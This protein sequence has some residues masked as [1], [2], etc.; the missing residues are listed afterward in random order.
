[1]TGHAPEPECPSDELLAG[2]IERRVSDAEREAIEQHVAACATCADVAAASFPASED[3][4][5]R[6]VAEPA[7]VVAVERGPR[8]SAAARVRPS[9]TRWAIAAGLVLAT[10]ALAYAALDAGLARVRDELARRAS[11]ALG[12]PVT[13]G[14]LGVGLSSD[15][16]GLVIRV[17]DVR[18]GGD[19][20]LSAE[21]ID[22]QLSLAALVARTLDVQRLRLL[23]PVIHLGGP[24][25]KDAGAKA[26]HV[27]GAN[28]LAA[29]LG[30]ASLEIVD[31][32]LVAAAA[33]GALRVDHVNGTASPNGSRVDLA[34]S[35]TGAGGTL[36]VDGSIPAGPSGELAATLTGQALDVG[37]LPLV[38][39]RVTGRADLSVALTGTTDSPVLQGRGVIRGGRARGWNPLPQALAALGAEV[40]PNVGAATGPDLAFD[41][42]R[43][44]ILRNA[45][46]WKVP[47][48]YASAPGFSIDA[49]A[50]QL[51]EDQ[52]LEGAG[53]VQLAAPLAAVVIAAVP[54]LVAQRDESG[55]LALPITIGG[56]LAAPQLTPLV[57]APAAVEEPPAG[58]ADTDGAANAAAPD[59]AA[60]AAPA[61]AS[62]DDAP[63]ADEP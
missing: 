44:V 29:T 32:T 30:R 57:A 38:R 53:S 11:V 7:P 10:A 50:I 47:R 26:G 27:G 46:G 13:I 3:T 43:L 16:R 24:P 18:I 63:A 37:Q 62:G 14:R 34:L 9:R 22:L 28:A 48:L 5:A 35:G 6:R 33:D 56:T 41:E 40:P 12:E 21:G 23:G 59:A 52:S 19:D 58:A 2:W 60:P 8:G 55:A 45:Q 25:P 20:G 1:M 15:L 4:L 61:D 51:F 49:S 31:G 39:D 17:R 42:L 54:S 36:N